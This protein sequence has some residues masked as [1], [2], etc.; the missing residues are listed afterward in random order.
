MNKHEE[1]KIVY[2]PGCFVNYWDPQIGEAVV[3]ILE[4]N[5]FRV[6]VPKHQCCG[7]ARV[8]YGDFK[9][10]CKEAT[11]LVDR[12]FT[13]SEQGYDIVTACPSCS[14]AIKED[15]PFLLNSQKAKLVSERTCF[16]SQY[17]NEL[18]EKG[19]L[20]TNFNRMSLSVAYHTP[21]HLKTQGLDGASIKLMTLIPGLH[22][23][24]LDRGCCGMAGTAG[25]KH[26]YYESSMS[27]GRALFER[28]QEI[29]V[30]VVAT[31]CAGCKIQIEQATAV[32]V[33]HPIVILDRAYQMG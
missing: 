31:D 22:A 14:L 23:I 18:H 10:A 12:L 16:L 24:D 8:G 28:I 33:I 4:K 6:I 1:K 30:Q 21:C 32:E 17:L 3:H 2:Y 7:V 5:G 15:Y 25:F 27:I 19:E 13:L 9:G 11:R 26:R 20:N 29:G